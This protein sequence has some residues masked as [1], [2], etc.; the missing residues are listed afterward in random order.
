MTGPCTQEGFFEAI[1][2]ED[3]LAM[4]PKTLVL[5][6]E[7]KEKISFIPIHQHHPFRTTKTL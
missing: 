7:L 3:S 2:D 1:L 4:S 5:R 6:T